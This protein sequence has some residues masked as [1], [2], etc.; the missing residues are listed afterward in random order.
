M[1]CQ[2]VRNNNGEIQQVLAPNGK[3]SIL[4][5]D[6]NK[7]IK[8]K[9]R[10]LEQYSQV[11]T[12]QFKEW[13]KDSKI[14]DSNGEPRLAYHGTNVYF[15]EF[16]VS[17]LGFY[18]PGLY[19]STD[20]QATM[21]FNGPVNMPVFLSIKN[22]ENINSE[23][24][25]QA[26]LENGRMIGEDQDGIVFM[27][28]SEIVAMQPNQVKSLYNQG[29]FSQ[30]S[31]SIYLQ[32]GDN[33]PFEVP[34]KLQTIA[35]KLYNKFNISYSIIND[36]SN[37]NR[38]WF[39][40]NGVTINLAHAKGDTAFHEYI[41]PFILVLEKQNPSLYN[42][43]ME[44]LST[45]MEGLKSISWADT[46][47]SE[48][49]EKERAQEALVNYLGK[50]S[51]QK[52]NKAQSPFNRF[53]NWLKSL[54]RKIN[55]DF[56]N[57]SLDTKL[58]DIAN[59]VVDDIYVADLRAMLQDAKILTMYQ[60]PDTELTYENVYDRIKDKIAILNA[61]IKSRKKG[62]QFK[63][64]ISILND[65]IQNQDEITSINN[66]VSNSIHYIEQAST[67]FESL[68]ASVKDAGKLTQ[69]QITYNLNIL[70]EIQQLLNVYSSLD[71]IKSLLLREGKD[72]TDDNFSKLRDAIDKKELIIEDFKSFALTYITEWLYPHLEY[73]NKNLEASGMTNMILT[74]EK[75][76]EQLVQA[77]RDISA[78]GQWLGTTINSRDPVSAA[79]ALALK[80][81]VYDNH[82]KDLEIKKYLMDE[83]KKARGTALYKTSKDEEEFN[84][85]FLKEVRVWEKVGVDEETGEDK[86]DYVKRL[87]FHQE[88]NTDEFEIAKKKFYDQ[89]GPRPSDP[90]QLKSWK[91]AQ[92]EWYSLN[93]V[94]NP[95]ADEIIDHNRRTMSARQFEEW[96]LTNTKEVD[97]IE[98]GYGRNTMDYYGRRAIPGTYNA[99]KGTFRALSGELILP[100][101]KYR[102]TKFGTLMRNPY[103]AKLYKT[104]QD[105]NA[106]LGSYALEHG[107][108]PQVSKG[109]N[110]FSDLQWK[111]GVKENLKKLGKKVLKGIEAENE[112][113]R[114]VQRQDKTEVKHIP[115]Y[116]VRKLNNSDVK[117]DL[118][119]TVLMYSQMANN[120][121]GMTE[122]E[123]NVVVLK[124]VLNGDFNLGIEGRSIA[125]TNAKGNQIFNAI[126][127][128]VVSKMTREDML[129]ARLNEFINDVV[130]GDSSF[131][132]TIN[133]LGQEISMDKLSG[134]VALVTAMQ[135]MAANV[136]G[137]ISNVAV[138]NFNNT[139]EAIGRR[140]YSMKD[141]G[142]AQ[143]EYAKHLPSL[144]AEAAGG[145]DSFLN[146]LADHYDV[147]QGEFKDHYGDNVSKGTFNKLMKTSSLFFLQK[148]GEH[149][150]QTT[151]MMSLMHARKLTDSKTGKEVNL[152]EALKEAKGDQQVMAERYGWSAEDDK[153]FRNRLH[154]LVKNL[155][156]VYNSFDK[157]MLSRRWYGKLALMFRKYF[158]KA[159][160]SRYGAKYVDYELGTVEGGYWREFASK[161]LADMKEYKFGVLQRMWTKEGYD[162][163]QKAAIN[164]TLYEM[165]VIIATFVLIGVASAD[166]DDKSWLNSEM[167]LQLTR[168]S[169]DITQ[170]INPADF[171]RVIRNPAAS[172][173]M[174]EK[175]ISWFT[176]LFH[177]FEEYQRASGFAKKGDKKLYIKTL[178]LLP[179]VRQFINLLT[180]EEQIKF[181]QLT[182][183]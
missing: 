109:G 31:N 100:G 174:I 61:T 107:I 96:W 62:D 17:G 159:I 176:Q 35:Q 182:G 138:G 58:S 98:Y 16:K 93:T 90:Q 177:P 13:F 137:G 173:N 6:I 121:R 118:L 152:Y 65:I 72:S 26:F 47:Y 4:F 106:A 14:T 69:S 18:G 126:T 46:N 63:E 48:L 29:D 7:V 181:Y 66:F 10:A 161:I 32:K 28:G 36:A 20:R 103:Y 183:R 33:S 53:I 3:E 154:A 158:F 141:W 43:L 92:G 127:K 76:R 130:Y 54:F 151:A 42:S 178:K 168:F 122:I 157:A 27:D 8:D 128:K 70:G 87:A 60:K 104:Y 172:I 164:K 73:T 145:E 11:H 146:E 5:D 150:I 94:V 51:E 39:N 77:L 59:M 119:S 45:D 175:W 135:N 83:Y 71:D 79:I 114:T 149:Q 116:Y 142:W 153:A 64:D 147:P 44:Q 84:K 97:N 169:A 52:Y 15:D 136:N 129:N 110:A 156:G 112:D 23:Q 101:E 50:L 75:F 85:Q 89:L 160:T 88:Y 132:Q 38:G 166:D 78:A 12:P 56:K 49:G 155:H 111:D 2:V 170:Y 57:M 148:G 91:K 165:A 22:P 81:V 68:R 37:P 115:V 99:K 163:F 125:K 140:F 19:F 167:E 74:K 41:H 162:E 120:Y 1:A 139:I 67:K 117:L 143:V 171:I 144:V 21:N 105:A 134:K 131:D 34:G 124:T 133:V 179:V 25:E 55:I 30:A 9:E 95:H 86:Y 123:P 24:E 113:D 80:D 102:N 40:G 108:I 82:V 180:P